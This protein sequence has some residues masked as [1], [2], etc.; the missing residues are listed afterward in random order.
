MVRAGE[1]E[2]HD[3]D[4]C[5]VLWN[6]CTRR[7][8]SSP[9]AGKLTGQKPALKSKEVWAIRARLEL[10][11]RI[12]DLALFNLAIDSK[13]RGCDLVRLTVGD[14]AA[15]QEIR[16]RTSIVQKKTGRPVQFE[17]TDQT[18]TAVKA[19]IVQH[20]AGLPSLLTFPP[21][22]MPASFRAGF[23]RSD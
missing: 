12:R 1:H 5:T 13:L 18:R 10:K 4:N 16:T 20:G 9:H 17:I 11:K 6:T 2:A 23:A 14:I 3:H 15:G 8:P 7:R 21:G 22:S 19:L